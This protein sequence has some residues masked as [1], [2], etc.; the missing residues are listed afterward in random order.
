MIEGFPKPFR[1]GR[2]R[3]GGGTLCYLCKELNYC[4]LPDDIESLS[5]EINYRKSKWLL[6]SIYHPPSQ[7]DNHFFFDCF[8]T[9]LD[10]R[11]RL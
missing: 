4:S 8:G 7:N 6:V 2:N 11:E 1:R 9:A 3:R 5:I 10:T